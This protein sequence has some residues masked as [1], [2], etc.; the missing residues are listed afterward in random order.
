M[1]LT[2][3]EKSHWELRIKCLN[4]QKPCCFLVILPL[5]RILLCTQA[6]QHLLSSMRQHQAPNM[7]FLFRFFLSG[8]QYMPRVRLV[9]GLELAQNTARWALFILWALL[10]SLCIH[11]IRWWCLSQVPSYRLYMFC[12]LN[13]KSRTNKKQ[14]PTQGPGHE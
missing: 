1:G 14:R 11:H 8:N 12:G 2:K 7:P 4:L 13:K 5:K 9:C 6:T 10:P 3:T